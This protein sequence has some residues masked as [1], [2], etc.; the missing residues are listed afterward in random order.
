M[1]S[2]YKEL[3]ILAFWSCFLVTYFAVVG[4]GKLLNGCATNCY[5]S[6]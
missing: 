2:V 3:V 6:C 1:A 5:G 4:A